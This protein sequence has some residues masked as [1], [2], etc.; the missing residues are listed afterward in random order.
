LRF[1]ISLRYCSYSSIGGRKGFVTGIIF[2]SA[3]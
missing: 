3:K 1:Q 2:Y